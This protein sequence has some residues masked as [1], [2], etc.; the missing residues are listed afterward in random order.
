[1]VEG[2]LGEEYRDVSF[3]DSQ[4][5]I[6]DQGVPAI[7]TRV[8]HFIPL[9]VHNLIF[10]M[11]L[12][13]ASLLRVICCFTHV[14]HRSSAINFLVS[15]TIYHSFMALGWLVLILGGPRR[16]LLSCLINKFEV[17]LAFN[18]GITYFSFNTILYPILE[19]VVFIHAT[20]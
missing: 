8:G 14:T 7:W 9:R 5:L 1:M 3:R 19:V 13:S 20:P 17:L 4:V 10:P 2:L 11:D 6:A 15:V 12:G 16:P 18:I